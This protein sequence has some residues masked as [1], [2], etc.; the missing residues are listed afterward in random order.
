MYHKSPLAIAIV[1]VVLLL[2]FAGLA[3]WRF[4]SI[5]STGIPLGPAVRLPGHIGQIVQTAERYLPT[6]HRN[7]DNDRFRLDLL[8]IA[9]ADPTRQETI[10]LLRDQQ[11]NAL[12]PMTK[13]LGG[14]ANLVRVQAL[15][16]LAVNLETRH[17]LR[18]SDIAKVN[19]ELAAFLASARCEFKD[20]LIVVSPDQRHAYAIDAATFK[21]E[22]VPVPKSAG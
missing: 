11:R 21:A 19:P 15:D 17:V 4:V 5:K 20:R 18:S 8:V 1:V 12:Q 9:L 6:L 7:P 2:L 3:A 22:A 13:I 16:L 14:T 10:T